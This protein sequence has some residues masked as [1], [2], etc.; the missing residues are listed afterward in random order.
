MIKKDYIEL[1]AFG[2][3]TLTGKLSIPDDEIKAVVLI[4]G[5]MG[6]TQKYYHHL[7]KFISE[8]GYVVLTFDYRGTGI[9]SPE[10]I[11]GLDVKLKDWA[12]DIGT[13]ITYLDKNYP[14]KKMIFIGHSVGGQIMGMVENKEKINQSLFLTSCTGYWNDISGFEKWKSLFL[15]AVMMPLVIKIWGFVNAKKLGVGENYPKGI[16]LQW[17]SWC[18]NKGYM[19]LEM[20]DVFLESSYYKYSKSIT[21]I[22]FTDDK[23]ANQTSIL[24][25][26][27]FYPNARISQLMISPSSLGLKKIGHIGF[28]SRKYKD[29]IWKVIIE[30]FSY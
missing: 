27:S 30:N 17:R 26:L 12:D 11:K 25:L 5:A 16:G 7:S 6:V 24:K 29:T 9:S 2:N 1:K 21:S 10:I 13:A 14:N 15:L 4:A 20:N 23:I 3:Y 18:L 28:L 8:K 19:R 22:W